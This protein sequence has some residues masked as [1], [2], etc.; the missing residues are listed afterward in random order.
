MPA[1][2]ISSS[3]LRFIVFIGLIFM[4]PSAFG[5]TANLGDVNRDNTI[6]IID[7]LLVARYSAGLPGIVLTLSLADVN[8]SGAVDVL[9]AMMIARYAA[10]IITRFPGQT[11]TP[12]P[13]GGSYSFTGTLP[14]G[15]IDN[16]QVVYTTTAS[17]DGTYVHVTFDGGAGFEWAWLYTPDYH[18]MTNA[19]GNIWSLDL[20]GYTRGSTLYY[21]FTV[22]KNGQE[23]NN[24]SARHIWMVGGTVTPTPVGTPTPTPTYTATPTPTGSGNYSLV[25]S[26]EF[27]GS[28]GPDW[29]FETGNG[30][31]GWGNNELEYYR[32]ENAYVS[33]GVLVIEAKKES[34]GGFNYTSARMKTQ[35]IRSWQYG[36]VEARMRMSLGQGIWPAFWMLGDNIS[37]VNWPACGEIDIMEHINNEST[38]YGTIH[39][40][41]NGHAYYTGQTGV[42]PADYHVYAIEWNNKAIKWYVDGVLYH[43]ANIENNINS[44][45]EFHRKFFILLNVAVGGN[46][47]GA[48][49][50]STVFPAYMYVDYV[51][52]YQ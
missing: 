18:A 31:G 1:G 39:W 41:S 38:I 24:S 23:A 10:G 7:A 42:N 37:T 22:R 21:Y 51:R 19:S 40:D 32:R 9:D 6:N 2:V 50:T 45:E 44:T 3:I 28:I 36:R 47:P 8:A 49:N 12:I 14:N 4:V 11:A 27:T 33:N 20:A 34:Y 46:W 25:W 43:E 52:V 15:L 29:V 17:F 16:T 5:Q 26:D 13:T 48:P 35:G 30:S